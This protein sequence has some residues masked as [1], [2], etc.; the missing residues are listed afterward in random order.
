MS[1]GRIHGAN[2]SRY[3]LIN[4]NNPCP[5]FWWASGNNC[6]KNSWSVGVPAQ[7]ITSLGSL[8]VSGVISGGNEIITGYTASAQYSTSAA[9]VLGLG[10]KW[11]T[12]EFNVFGNYDSNVAIF[13][14]GSSIVVQ[15]GVNGGGYPKCGVR[16]G[17]TAETANFNLTGWCCPIGGAWPAIQFQQS[18][19]SVVPVPPFC[20]ST[21]APS[22][23]NE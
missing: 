19:A 7:A 6:Y 10:S 11:N 12:A 5:A 3:R 4:Y 18:N 13:N 9:S 1:V 14:A 8:R 15:I 2:A 22:V 21:W 20:L 16:N 23:F 17:F